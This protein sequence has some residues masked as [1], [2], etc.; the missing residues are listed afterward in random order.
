M[1]PNLPSTKV[2]YCFDLGS[3]GLQPCGSCILWNGGSIIE[4]N[5]K[6]AFLLQNYSKMAWIT[7]TIVSNLVMNENIFTCKD[8]EQ[9]GDICG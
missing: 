8:E 7:D 3:E 1:W 9:I 2:T 5:P 4:V 6:W